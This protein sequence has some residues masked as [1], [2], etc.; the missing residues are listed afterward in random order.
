MDN[1]PPSNLPKLAVPVISFKKGLAQRCQ[2]CLK[3]YGSFFKEHQC[4]RCNR[5]VCDGCSKSKARVGGYH[6]FCIIFGVP[7]SLIV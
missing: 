2:L 1:N 4:K 3:N 7:F 6:Y 5:S